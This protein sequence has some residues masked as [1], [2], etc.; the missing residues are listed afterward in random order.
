MT[1][2]RSSS[3]GLGDHGPLQQG[4]LVLHGRHV[5]EHDLLRH[6]A[7]AASVAVRALVPLLQVIQDAKDRCHLHTSWISQKGRCG[8]PEQYI[9]PS[10]YFHLKRII[11]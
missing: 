6:W 10:T 11:S 4:Q 9:L 2:A 5:D 1:R 8:Y 7:P 3:H